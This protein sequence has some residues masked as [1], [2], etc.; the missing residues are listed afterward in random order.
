MTVVRSE[1]M[2]VLT[3]NMEKKPQYTCKDYREEMIL[4]GLATRLEQENLSEE[5]R[6]AIQVEIE[7]LKESMH[8]E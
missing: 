4:V 6:R 1:K 2:N 3:K 7:K 5:E 8:L